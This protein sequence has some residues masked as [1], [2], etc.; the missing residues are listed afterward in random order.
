MSKTRVRTY[1]HLQNGTDNH[2]FKGDKNDGHFYLRRQANRR[3]GNG[4]QLRA[5]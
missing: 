5:G 2:R 3:K 4:R 1:E